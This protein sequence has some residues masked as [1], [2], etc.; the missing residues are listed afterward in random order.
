MFKV[1]GNITSASTHEPRGRRAPTTG[2]RR[3]VSDVGGNAAPAPPVDV[4]GIRFE[5]ESIDTALAVIELVA[6]RACAMRVT[7]SVANSN[8]QHSA[9]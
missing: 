6:I 2:L 9:E 1:L 8:G 5:P 7:A 4:K 3:P